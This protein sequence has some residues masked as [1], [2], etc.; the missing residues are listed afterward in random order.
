MELRP[1]HDRRKAPGEIDAPDS[2]LSGKGQRFRFRR[3]FDPAYSRERRAINKLLS[4]SLCRFGK[5]TNAN[6]KSE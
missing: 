6:S 1:D 2:G 5:L 4:N 3:Y